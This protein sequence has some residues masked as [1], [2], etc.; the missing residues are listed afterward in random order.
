MAAEKGNN[1]SPGRPTG[2]KAEFHDEQA[3]RLA[4]LGKTV[5][6]IADSFGESKTTIKRWFKEHPSFWSAV[7]RGREY[8]DAQVAESLFKR[9]TGF[10]TKEQRAFVR[11]VGDFSQVVEVKDIEIHYPPDP[12]AA[13]NWLKNRQP[14]KWR[15]KQQVE[16]SGTIDLTM[17]LEEAPKDEA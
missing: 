6:E 7:T 10:R 1:Y 4:L 8:A 14:D 12:G 17:N 15:D 2:Y 13:M 3:Y 9:A 16:L 5:E 11:S